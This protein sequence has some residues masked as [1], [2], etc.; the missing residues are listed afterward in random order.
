[1]PFGTRFELRNKKMPNEFVV[2]VEGMGELKKVE[3]PKGPC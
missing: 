1:V 2:D 3:Q